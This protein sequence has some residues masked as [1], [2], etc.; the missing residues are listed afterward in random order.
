ALY[1]QNK[2]DRLESFYDVRQPD[3][4]RFSY[5]AF[6][7]YKRFAG[8]IAQAA[9]EFTVDEDHP[10]GIDYSIDM[11]KSIYSYLV[12]KRRLPVKA[13]GESMFT[14]WRRDWAVVGPALWRYNGDPD[15]FE[16]AHAEVL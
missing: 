16:R 13:E 4:S 12:E 9:R 7:P 14:K 1:D 6:L 3:Y 11:L 15:E 8:F 5:E 2:N 10:E